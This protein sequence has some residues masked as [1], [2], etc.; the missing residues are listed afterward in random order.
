MIPDH[1]DGPAMSHQE[2]Y[3][4]NTDYTDLLEGRDAS[5]Y[6]KYADHLR[7]QHKGE[8][9]LDVGC[10]VGQV[11]QRLL[12]EGFD[13]HGVDVSEPSIERAKKIVSTCRLYDGKTLP[14]ADGNF[15]S[16]GALNV[17]EH[18]EEPELFISELVRVV[19]PGGKIVLSS[20]NF[21]RVLGFRDYHVKMRGFA[22][23]FANARRLLRKRREMKLSPATV[24]FDRMTPIMKQPFAPD[25]DA[26]VVT[27]PLEMAFF[28]KQNGCSIDMVACTDRYVA[29]PIDKV[30]NL[31]PLRFLMFNAFVVARKGP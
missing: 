11:I 31:T 17:L 8:R 1:A 22:N 7:T 19:R 30:L 15:A 23:K 29:W 14:Y 26:I 20:P 27:N 13:V 5:F 12:A 21:L 28:L 6:A 10:G 9:V 16:A 25:D 24:R 18:V 2:S 4:Y 3:R